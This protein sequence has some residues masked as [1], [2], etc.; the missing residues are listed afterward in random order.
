MGHQTHPFVI[1]IIE[2]LCAAHKGPI[3]ET[4]LRWIDVHFKSEGSHEDACDVEGVSSEEDV[5]DTI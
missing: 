1:V 4:P 5:V 3:N 2:C